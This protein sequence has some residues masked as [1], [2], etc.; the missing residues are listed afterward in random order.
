MVKGTAASG[1]DLKSGEVDFIRQCD[2]SFVTIWSSSYET[3]KH[4]ESVPVDS[5]LH[6]SS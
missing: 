2:R 6:I 4:L 1:N 5:M 3:N